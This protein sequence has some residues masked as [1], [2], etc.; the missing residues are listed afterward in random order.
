MI[1]LAPSR[2]ASS[3]ARSAVCEVVHLER[4]AAPRPHA[5]VA[6]P[7]VRRHEHDRRVAR[8]N[9]QR[10]RHAAVCSDR[11]AKRLQGIADASRL[12]WVVAVLGL[13]AVACARARTTGRSSAPPH[14]YLVIVDGL[15]ADL[16]DPALMPRLT[17]SDLQPVAV[18]GEGRARSCRRAR[19]RI[20]R[21]C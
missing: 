10:Q 16:V 6:P 1:A 2:A 18:R 14:V 17:G 20:M 8:D 11:A 5:R 3:C 12:Q 7:G 9:R 4:R 13:V 21:R 19:T 15:G